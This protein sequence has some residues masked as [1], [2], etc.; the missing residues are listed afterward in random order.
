[1]VTERPS[2]RLTL[3]AIAEAA[4]SID[5]VFLHSPQYQCEPLS[6]LLGCRLTLKVETANPIRSF[7]GRGADYFLSQV[8][9]RGDTRHLVCAS[10]GNFGQAMAYSCR[11]HDRPLTVFVNEDANPVKAARLLEL[12]ADVRLAGHDFDAAKSEGRNHSANIGAWF[13]EDGREPEIS[14]GAGSIGVELLARGDLFDSALIP[15]GNGALIAGIARWLKE[16]TPSTEVVG[17]CSAGADAMEKSWREGRIVERPRVDTIADGIAVRVPI[18]EAVDDMTGVVDEVLL[19]DDE[20]II[21]A[22]RLLWEHAGLLSEPA[23]A[24]GVAAI[25]AEPERFRDQRVATVVTGSNLTQEE[26]E[27]WLRPA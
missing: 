18:P 14:E 26:I 23:G 10:T 21:E 5:P 1:M 27:R 3:D 20:P 9:A 11:R 8:N 12:G 25:A 24:V 2:H 6:E 22:M 16:A 17:V 15:V 7:K 4:R 19:V 13:V